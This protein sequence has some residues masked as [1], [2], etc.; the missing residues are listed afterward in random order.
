MLNLKLDL[1]RRQTLFIESLLE[2]HPEF[3]PNLDSRFTV[4]ESQIVH[5]AFMPDWDHER[6][7]K[8]KF[9]KLQRESPQLLDLAE[10]LLIRF[11]EIHGVDS[12]SLTL[13]GAQVHRKEP[14]EVS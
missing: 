6:N 4:C 2:A 11:C 7:Y 12:S 9:L 10:L 5:G 8:T 1:Y 14:R 3:D 13:I